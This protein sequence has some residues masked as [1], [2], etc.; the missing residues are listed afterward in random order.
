MFTTGSPHTNITAEIESGFIAKDDLVPFRCS[1]KPLHS[2]PLQTDASM[3][4]HVMSTAI[5]IFLQLGAL[6]WF[7]KT[8]RPLMKVLPVSRS[9]PMKQLAVSM[10][11]LRCGGVHTQSGLIDELL[12]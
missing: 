7:E 8:R 12:A 10:H 4:A 11:L 1:L 3:A 9:R 6:L 2:T 5:S